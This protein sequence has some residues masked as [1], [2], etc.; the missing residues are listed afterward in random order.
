VI[1]AHYRHLK[2]GHPGSLL[3]RDL[4][5]VTWPALAHAVEQTVIQSLERDSTPREIANVC[6]RCRS[7]I[8]SVD[9]IEVGIAAQ[10]NLRDD[11]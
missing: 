6:A 8:I 4:F 9:F 5:R 1:H 3:S 11:K 10:R 2:T 7:R